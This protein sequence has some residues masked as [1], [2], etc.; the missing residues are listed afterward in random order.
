VALGFVSTI[1]YRDTILNGYFHNAGHANSIDWHPSRNLFTSTYADSTIISWD[2]DTLEPYWRAVQLSG[3]KSVTFTAVD[4]ILHGDR[5]VVDEHLV[6]YRENDEG[7]I[8]PLT[9]TESE[10]RIGESIYAPKE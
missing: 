3:D 10:E 5:D 8:E 6:Y 9:R 1:Q 2:A 4:Q 7:R